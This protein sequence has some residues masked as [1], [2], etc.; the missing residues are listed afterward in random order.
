MCK[1]KYFRG[2]GVLLTTR[3]NPSTT[4]GAGEPP[5]GWSPSLTHLKH[6]SIQFVHRHN[7]TNKHSTH[8][9]SP[10]FYA[11]NKSPFT[12]T[13]CHVTQQQQLGDCP[14]DGQVYVTGDNI[15][16]DSVGILSLTHL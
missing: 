8:F 6:N 5:H 12:R 11:T 1:M 10:S 3:L 4:W 14:A 13:P 2:V 16:T 15:I 7:S 9:L